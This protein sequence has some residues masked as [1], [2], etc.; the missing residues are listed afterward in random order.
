MHENEIP[1][2]VAAVEWRT[3]ASMGSRESKDASVLKLLSFSL[4]RITGTL[5]VPSSILEH[6]PPGPFIWLLRCCKSLQLSGMREKKIHVPRNSAGTLK[7]I[8]FSLVSA[9]DWSVQCD[10]PS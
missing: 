3:M 8:A 4:F 6:L 1:L 2:V 9:G 10:V 5:T 7:K